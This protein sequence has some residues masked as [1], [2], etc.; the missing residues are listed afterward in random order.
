MGRS[1][2]FARCSARG[3]HDAMDCNP[4]PMMENVAI[5]PLSLISNRPCI[6]CYRRT[7]AVRL[8]LRGQADPKG[9]K[10]CGEWPV[11]TTRTRQPEVNP[12]RNSDQG[13][14]DQAVSEGYY[15]SLRSNQLGRHYIRLSDPV[16][17]ADPDRSPS[18]CHI[19]TDLGRGSPP[20]RVGL[21]RDQRRDLSDDES[22][23]VSGG[24][25]FRRGQGPSTP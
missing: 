12:W 19:R 3:E 25:L 1:R 22:A 9:L 5:A 23:Q 18:N 16:T 4:G 24:W 6:S 15:V 14:S 21:V 10:E 7:P 17:L 2:V 20:R 8:A 11:R 13:V